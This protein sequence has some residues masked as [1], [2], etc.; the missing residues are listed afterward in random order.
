MAQSPLPSVHL[1]PSPHK[2]PHPQMTWHRSAT[3]FTCYGFLPAPQCPSAQ[4]LQTT[5]RETSFGKSDH[6]YRAH[7][8]L[9]WEIH[10][11]MALLCR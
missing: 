4:G 10:K 7:L 5:L 8:V 6:G 11:K 1:P 9:G 3:R 2:A